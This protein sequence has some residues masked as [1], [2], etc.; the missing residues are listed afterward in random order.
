[1]IGQC[2]HHIE[3]AKNMRK[4]ITFIIT[5]A[6]AFLSLGLVYGHHDNAYSSFIDNFDRRVYSTAT[7]NDD[8]VIEK[9]SLY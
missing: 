9:L 6:I 3:E 2:H 4:F 8:F 7:L 5:L 1:M